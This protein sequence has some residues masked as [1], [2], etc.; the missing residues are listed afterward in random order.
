MLSILL[1]CDG[2]AGLQKAVVDHMGSRPP[3]SDHGLFLVQIWLW[4][5]LWSFF[6]VQP[7]SWSSLVV[8]Y[9]PLFVAHHNPIEKWFTVA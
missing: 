4:K 1:R 9:N 5:V 2:F 6:L 7:L 3:S 8:I